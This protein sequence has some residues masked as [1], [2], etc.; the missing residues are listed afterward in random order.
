MKKYIFIVTLFLI[1]LIF[2]APSGA[3]LLDRGNGLIYDDIQNITWLEYANYSGGTMNWDAAISWA[4]NFA[5]QGY[6]DWRLPTSDTSCTGNGCTGSEMGYLY[7]NYNVASD[8][9]NIFTDVKPYM[10]WSATDYGPDPSKAWRFNFG[11]GYQSTSSKTYARYAWAVRDGDS[12]PPVAPE[13]TGLV[14]FIAGGILLAMMCLR[15]NKVLQ[16]HI[17]S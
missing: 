15:K 5:F 14:L 16:A 7:Y 10:Y 1:T 9:P 13:P 11:T 8:L 2:A 17:S 4:D 6:D 12:S 3:N